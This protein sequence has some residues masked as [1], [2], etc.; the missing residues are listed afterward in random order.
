MFCPFFYVNTE[1]NFNSDIELYQ[2]FF[3][4]TLGADEVSTEFSFD[5]SEP[6]FKN[7]VAL[8]DCDRLWQEKDANF[9]PQKEKAYKL[10]NEYLHKHGVNC[11]CAYRMSV[12]EFF[13][14]YSNSYWTDV[15]F[16]KDHPEL[17]CVLRDGE[18]TPVCSYAFKE[19][20][21]YVISNFVKKIK[22]N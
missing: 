11:Y 5:C 12:A 16:V 17:Y 14:P 10:R 7:N 20:R 4:L 21:D 2:R 13:E 19:T 1:E 15:K 3:P 6:Y 22:Q 9:I 8:R 18:K